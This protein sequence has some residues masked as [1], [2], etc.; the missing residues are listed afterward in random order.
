MM[1]KH[2]RWRKSS[3]SRKCQILDGLFRGPGGVNETRLILV[4]FVS[5][6]RER[7]VLILHSFGFWSIISS[8]FIPKL[9]V[10]IFWPSL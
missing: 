3:V 2:A 5:G 7:I 6:V 1:A 8:L 10:G 9:V 4:Y